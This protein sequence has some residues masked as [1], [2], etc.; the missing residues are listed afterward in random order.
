M[1]YLEEGVFEHEVGADG[2]D[3]FREEL[4]AEPGGLFGGLFEGLEEAGVVVGRKEGVCFYF[5]FGFEGFLGEVGVEDHGADFA[6]LGG[7]EEGVVGALFLLEGEEGLD[8]LD[9]VDGG[10]RGPV[11]WFL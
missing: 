6:E 5:L 2:S 10:R 8:V 3:L 1:L 4:F 11:H 7:S 9:G